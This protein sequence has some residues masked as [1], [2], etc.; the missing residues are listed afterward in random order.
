MISINFWLMTYFMIQCAVFG[1]LLGVAAE[2]VKRFRHAVFLWVLA[3][4]W[5]VLIAWKLLCGKEPS[6]G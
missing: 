4:F 2:D 1:L 5:P 6:N 3:C